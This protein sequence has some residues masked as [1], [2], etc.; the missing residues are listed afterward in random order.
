MDTYGWSILLCFIGH[1]QESLIC[2]LL[3]ICPCP[4]VLRFYDRKSFA[5]CYCSFVR[6]VSLPKFS[7]NWPL[8]ATTVM[9]T[10]LRQYIVKLGLHE[11]IKIVENVFKGLSFLDN[12]RDLIQARDF[13]S[14]ALFTEMNQNSQNYASFS[15][16]QNSRHDQ[17][18]VVFWFGFD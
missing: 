9:I 14:T 8:L 3:H 7:N 16:K 10:L 15:K 13:Y 6:V 4:E 2:I 17:F 5:K 11:N 12:G 1:L 18:P